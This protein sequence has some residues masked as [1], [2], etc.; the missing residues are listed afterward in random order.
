MKEEEERKREGEEEKQTKRSNSVQHSIENKT[1][2]QTGTVEPV[3]RGH[4]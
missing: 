2:Q 1:G 4:T 3:T